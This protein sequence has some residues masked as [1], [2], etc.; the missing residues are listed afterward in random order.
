MNDN[1]LKLEGFRSKER[2]FIKIGECHRMIVLVWSAS[3][4]GRCDYATR[5]KFIFI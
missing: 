1:F 5:L 4:E 3:F 2:K